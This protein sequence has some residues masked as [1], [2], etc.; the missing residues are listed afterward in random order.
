M[1]REDTFKAVADSTRRQILD[2]LREKGELRTGDIAEAFPRISRQAVSKHL[3][4]LHEAALI[5]E[6]PA[7]DGRERR[8]HLTPE[9]L[10]EIEDWLQRYDALW[11]ERI[12][13]LKSL[14]EAQNPPHNQGE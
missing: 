2:M 10:L 7:E 6:M 3:R 8:Y 1:S 14:V 9:P 5:A 11:T 4:I 13:T 12:E